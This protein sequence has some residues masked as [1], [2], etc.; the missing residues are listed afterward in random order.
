MPTGTTVGKNDM[1]GIYGSGIAKPF[2]IPGHI[3]MLR[4][5]GIPPWELFIYLYV[6]ELKELPVLSF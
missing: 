6:Y 3:P 5:Y 1:Q 2:S 4:I